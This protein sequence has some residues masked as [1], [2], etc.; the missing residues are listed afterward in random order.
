MY[1]TLGSDNTC[2]FT[3]FHRVKNANTQL[4]WSSDT[5]E[6]YRKYTTGHGHLFHAMVLEIRHLYGLD[7]CRN[8]H[9]LIIYLTHFTNL[10][11]RKLS[12]MYHRHLSLYDIGIANGIIH[13]D[14]FTKVSE[15]QYTIIVTPSL[16]GKLAPLNI[17]DISVILLTSQL[18]ISWAN[19]SALTMLLL[20][21]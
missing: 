3:R 9:I 5:R 16:G 6:L 15:T 13:S 17:E 12:V 8:E 1:C 19:L 10:A 11:T 20:R 4:I 21:L 18:P 2:V 14:S 7:H